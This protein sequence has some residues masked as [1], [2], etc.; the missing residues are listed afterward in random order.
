VLVSQQGEEIMM[1]GFEHVGLVV[2]DVEKQKTFY[3]D[4]LGL[5]VLHEREVL[6]PPTGD[7]TGIPEVRRKLIFLGNEK[8]EG[9]LE[10]V[11]YIDPPSPMGQPLY[12]NQVNSIHL[13]FN[14]INLQNHYR[15]LSEKGIRFLTPPKVIEGP[16]GVSVCLCYAQDPEGNWLEFKE[17]LSKP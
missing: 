15:E 16:G 14:I 2:R 1:T 17:V 8:G 9:F 11:H 5:Q 6:A 10:L 13:C 12:P 3:R 4:I 7:H